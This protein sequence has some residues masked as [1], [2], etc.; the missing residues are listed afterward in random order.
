MTAPGRTALVTGGTGALGQAVTRRLLAAGDT[1]WVPYVVDAERERLLAAVDTEQA[2]RLVLERVDVADATA[3][4]RFVSGAR[5][6]HG[7]IDALITLV[8]GFT[9]GTLLE[10]D[11]ASWDRMLDLNLTTVFTATRAIVPHMVA[12]GRGRVV[13][14][15]SR[16]VVPPAGGF[17]AYTVAKAAVIAFTQA[18]AEELRGTRVT[19]NCVLPSTMDT[20]ANRAAMPTSDRKGW[21]SV[22]SVAAAIAF[23]ASEDAAE[24]TGALVSV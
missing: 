12:A 2:G 17:I 24:V 21:V 16:A 13:T 18:L 4:G 23:L 7:G 14:I 20:P 1:V 10:T 19:A 15:G 5:A 9:G 11:R 22:D 3:L 8:G 6:R